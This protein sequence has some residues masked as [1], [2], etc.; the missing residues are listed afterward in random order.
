MKKIFFFNG[1]GM[2]DEILKS[3]KN[4]TDYEIEIVNFPYQIEMKKILA[5][6]KV[7]FIAWSFGVFYLNTFLYKNKG[8]KYEKAIAING[9]PYTIGKYGINPKMFNMTLTDLSSETLLKFYENMD[10]DKT[11]KKPKKKFEEIKVE[12]EYFKD[13]YDMYGEEFIDFYYI[14]ENDRIIPKQKQEKFCSE[15]KY[16]YKFIECGHYPFSYFKDF[17]DIIKC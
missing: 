7:I 6:E 5:C 15:R 17:K 9:T 3:V 16:K 12:L 1:W 10:I 14:G 11:F 8:L 13:V 4:S 2:D